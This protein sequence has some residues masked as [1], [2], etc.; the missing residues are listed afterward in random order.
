[1]SSETG[2]SSSES[3]VFIGGPNSAVDEPSVV[4]TPSP[5]PKTFDKE[6]VEQLR[7]E[8][9][10]HRVEKQQEAKKNEALEAKLKAFEDSQLSETE[11]FQNEFAETRKKAETFETLAR[12][13]ELTAKLA[14]ASRDE[15]IS[16]VKAAVK[17][18]DR[19]LIE[20]G[21]D[22]SIQNMS[23]V[24]SSLRSEYPSLFNPSFKAP[25]TGVTNPAKAPSEKKYTREDLKSM[26]PERR[27]ELLESGA[28]KHLL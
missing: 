11:R 13:Y 16:D 15:N 17:L 24:I 3:E 6:Y 4:D 2:V 18:A 22:G 25:N 26:S 5:E 20:Y 28:F 19:G 8:A 23:D 27:V 12:E 14:M 10:K 21:D 1:M 7:K 9:A